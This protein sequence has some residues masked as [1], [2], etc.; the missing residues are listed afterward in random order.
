[1]RQDA[2]GNLQASSKSC[3]IALV[4]P[5][6]DALSFMPWRGRARARVARS[7]RRGWGP[8]SALC[9][10]RFPVAR[11]ERRVPRPGFR[12]SRS[13]EGV[14]MSP[15][16]VDAVLESRDFVLESRD[17]VLGTRDVVPG[18]PL[19]GPRDP[20]LRFSR[21]EISFSGPAERVQRTDFPA[22]SSAKPVRITRPCRRATELGPPASRA[23]ELLADQ[24][25][26]AAALLEGLL[27]PDPLFATDPL[28]RRAVP[29]P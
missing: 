19:G 14:S 27:A 21:A 4:G 1:M 22:R 23:S 11:S 29:P 3:E 10:S 7:E 2:G 26:E 13:T 16:G 9:G 24:A 15:R 20:L 12:V 5:L 28:D 17:S 18:T 8:R 6:Q 25:L